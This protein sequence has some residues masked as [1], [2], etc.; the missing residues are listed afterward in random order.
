M[1]NV[2]E[3]DYQRLNFLITQGI[4]HYEP[5][6]LQWVGRASDGVEVG[7]GNTKDKVAIY[8]ADRPEPSMW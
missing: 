1:C 8:L 5:K 2:S 7:L 6:E 3:K 4:I